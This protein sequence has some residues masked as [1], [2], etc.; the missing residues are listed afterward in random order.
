VIRR[1]IGWS[2]RRAAV[3]LLDAHYWARRF[4]GYSPDMERHSER[5][6]V[7]AQRRYDRWRMVWT[8]LY[9]W[10]QGWETP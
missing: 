2:L 9:G 7:K 3:N 10:D 8:V 4:H 1:Y 6:L 5:A